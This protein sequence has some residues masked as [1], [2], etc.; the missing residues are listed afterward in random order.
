MRC[1]LLAGRTASPPRPASLHHR[2]GMPADA[3]LNMAVMITT[4]DRPEELAR[5]LAA[6]AAAT[7]P[8]GVELNWV[9]VDN[10]SPAQEE[11][12]RRLA[13]TAGLAITYA[14]EPVRG[15]ASPRNRALGV[16]LATGA[17]ILL[18]IDDDV[19]AEPDLLVAH[20]EGL[21]SADA[22]VSMGGQTGRDI[23]QARRFRK[24]K[25]ATLNVAF[26]RWLVD[27]LPDQDG[28]PG[29]R[30]DTRLNLT[31]FEDHEF[32][33][34]AQ[35]RGARITRNGAARVTLADSRSSITQKSMTDELVATYLYAT[36]RN[37]TYLRRLRHGPRAAWATATY[38]LATLGMRT[39]IN[40][41]LSLAARH[42][43]PRVAAEARRH[44]VQDLA[45]MHGLRHGLVMPGVERA[46][47]KRGEII[48]IVE[49]E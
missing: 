15:Y 14:N 24:M 4:R 21:K 29:L 32:F 41:P 16:S 8:P 13:A 9:V 46:A 11:P 6:L 19:A 45:Y 7:T 22:D 34:E 26:R 33:Y 25:V 36:A 20:L 28:S 27:P 17:D 2:P 5:C 47:A 42:I 1:T 10:A 39:A 35:A 31:G 3:P 30:F 23:G 18:F 43:A 12:I 38:M 48:E 40:A 44:V 49:G 37:L